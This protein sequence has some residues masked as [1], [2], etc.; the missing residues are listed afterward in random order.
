MKDFYL[1]Q[2]KKENP[3]QHK[4]NITK[5]EIIRNF[6]TLKNLYLKYSNRNETSTRIHV[7]YKKPSDNIPILTV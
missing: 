2:T 1:I 7:L 6:H 3:S 4:V 5:Y